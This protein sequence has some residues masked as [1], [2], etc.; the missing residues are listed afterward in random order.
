[1]LAR[2][3]LSFFLVL[4]C[5]TPDTKGKTRRKKPENWKQNEKYI[6]KFIMMKT[7]NMNAVQNVK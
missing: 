5:F 2:V 4:F 6:H 3:F 7:V 1:M